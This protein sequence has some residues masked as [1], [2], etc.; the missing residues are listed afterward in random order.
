MVPFP[1]QS[2]EAHSLKGSNQGDS[3]LLKDTQWV[4][5][6]WVFVSEFQESQVHRRVGEGRGSHFSEC[7]VDSV[8]LLAVS[9]SGTHSS[10]ARQGGNNLFILN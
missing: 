4:M 9:S 8:A 5:I 7:T 10:D 2:Q 3:L 6:S 1:Y